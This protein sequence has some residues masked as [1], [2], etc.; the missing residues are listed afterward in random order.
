MKVLGIDMGFARVG[1]A[2]LDTEVG[3]AFPRE[4]ISFASYLS[5][6]KSLIDEEGI[7]LIVIG[8]PDGGGDID[9]HRVA[10]QK[11]KLRLEESFNISVECFDERYTSRIAEQSLFLVGKGTHEVKKVSDSI[12][13][14]L[15]LQGWYERMKKI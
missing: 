5:V 7:E 14:V 6:L 10:I 15:I 13:A 3:I 2:V 8:D 9:N 4:V 12:S 1:V 11:E